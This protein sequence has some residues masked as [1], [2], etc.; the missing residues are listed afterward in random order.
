MMG[1]TSFMLNSN[2]TWFNFVLQDIYK[3][4][5]SEGLCKGNLVNKKEK[6]NYGE[7]KKEEVITPMAYNTEDNI[8]KE[9]DLKKN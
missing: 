2:I 6:K 8:I 4:M 5:K 3:V 9:L 7:N 1:H